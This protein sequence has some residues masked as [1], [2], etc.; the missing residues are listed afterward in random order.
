MSDERKYH[1]SVKRERERDLAVKIKGI[2]STWAGN[3]IPPG[4]PFVV[5]L[6]GHLFSKFTKN[7]D[8]PC[9]EV[10]MKTMIS[11]TEE[12]LVEFSARTG[13]TASDE[14][15][16]VFPAVSNVNG[17]HIYSGRPQK[18]VS[19]MAGFA[20]IRFNHWFELYG[21]AST[22][23][24]IYMAKR[25]IAYFDARVFATGND[26]IALDAVIWRYVHD[27]YRN[28]VAAVGQKHFMH[29]QL[30]KKST[31]DIKKMLLEANIL[32]NDY[33][34]HLFHGTFVKKY[35]VEVDSM[36]PLS[37]ESI[38]VIRSRVRSQTFN[39]IELTQ[40]EQ[41]SFIMAKYWSNC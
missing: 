30:F 33:P 35:L 2:E 28:G 38:K 21:N 15:S 22:K 37:N 10:F 40:Y 9:D 36:N 5:R 7:L 20:S 34:V 17:T 23:P 31:F 39:L 1:I 4:T 18:I 11:V 13:Y 16:L 25:S 24:E 8:G 6:D 26:S 19:L 32:L 3:N 27:T 29:K 41:E 12:L 14:I